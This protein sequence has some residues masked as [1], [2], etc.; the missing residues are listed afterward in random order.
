MMKK[1]N[2]TSPLWIWVLSEGEK[3][4]RYWRDLKRKLRSEGG[5]LYD[6]LVQLKN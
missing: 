5:Q 2:G 6:F 4:R 1:K 3:P